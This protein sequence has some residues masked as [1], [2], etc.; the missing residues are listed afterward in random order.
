MCRAPA[1]PKCPLGYS[2]N[3]RSFSRSISRRHHVG[4]HS[5]ATMHLV[6]TISTPPGI[7]QENWLDWSIHSA[8]LFLFIRKTMRTEKWHISTPMGIERSLGSLRR[9]LSAYASLLKGIIIDVERNFHTGTLNQTPHHTGF[10]HFD[11]Y[12]YKSYE[13]QEK[14]N[15]TSHFR[16]ILNP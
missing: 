11:M 9:S 14:S 12:S 7:P 10:S 16:L 5:S 15:V 8:M 4:L 2:R 1:S 3:L 6:I 13:Y